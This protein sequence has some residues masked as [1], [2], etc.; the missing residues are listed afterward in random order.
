MQ[1]VTWIDSLYEMLEPSTPPS[2]PHPT[3]TFLLIQYQEEQL[4]MRDSSSISI[5]SLDR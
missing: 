2:P 4:S 1:I 3:H 5:I